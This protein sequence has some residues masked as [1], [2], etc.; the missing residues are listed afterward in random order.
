MET[1]K[2]SV[3][4]LYCPHIYCMVEVIN[5]LISTHIYPN[6]RLKQLPIVGSIAL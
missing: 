6:Q 2:Q 4:S 5:L 1:S 3:K